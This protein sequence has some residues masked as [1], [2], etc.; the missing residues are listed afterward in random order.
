MTVHKLKGSVGRFK[1]FNTG[2]MEYSI[3]CAGNVLATVDSISA[4]YR[5]AEYFNLKH[6]NGQPMFSDTGM[7]LD[8]EGRRSVFDDVDQ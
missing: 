7:M 1:I 6:S 8:E 4:A 3:E 2:K 5:K